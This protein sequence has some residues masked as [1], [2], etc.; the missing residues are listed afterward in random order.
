MGSRAD[1]VSAKRRRRAAGRSR[2][3]GEPRYFMPLRP[4]SS[5]ESV[6]IEPASV[7]IGATSS[8]G[9]A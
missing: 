4:L 7:W 5:I 2:G 6:G 8:C 9:A 1:G 3:S